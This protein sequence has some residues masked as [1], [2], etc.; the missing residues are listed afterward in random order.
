MRGLSTHL[1]F[2]V[3]AASALV[4]VSGCDG[5]GTTMRCPVGDPQS[6]YG[7]IERR[8]KE[9][10]TLYINVGSEPEYLDPTLA[11]DGASHTLVNELFEGL[12]AKHP[13]DAHPV[14]GV[15]ARYQVSD[16]NTLW[17]FHLR[18]E[19][20]WSDGKPV[21]A[22]DFVYAWIRGLTAATGARNATILYPIKNG[23]PFHQGKL[24]V[25]AEAEHLRPIPDIHQ[26]G[27]ELPKG[28]AVSILT[29]DPKPGEPK[30]E[31]LQVEVFQG[32]PTFE[33]KAAA[34]P[35]PPL[36]GFVPALSLRLDASVLGMRAV[37]DHML[38]VELEE[39]TPY[40]LEL[41]AYNSYFPV[42]RDVIERWEAAGQPDLWTRKE[43]I[44]SNGPYMLDTWK[45]RYELAFVRNPHHWSYDELAIHRIVFIEVEDYHSTMNLYQAGEIDW[46]GPSLSL[47]QNFMDLLE[48]KKDFSRSLWI[49]TY[50]YEFNTSKKPVDDA[51]V[52]R[53]LG[54][55][56]DKQLIIDK[57]TRADQVPAR[58][59]VPP[60]T[61]SGY[62]KA[63]EAARAAGT[64]PF[65]GKGHDFD[66]VLA[67]ELLGQAGY[68]VVERDGGWYAQ[69]F[70]QLE[71]LYNTSEGHRG[72][73]VAIQDMW[74][75]HLG[76]TAA[77]RNEEW[78]VLIK[79]VRDGHFQVVRYG[80]TADYNHPHT[81]L[82]TFLSYSQNNHTKWKSA[83]Y[84]ALVEKAAR[85]VDPA[86]S[87][88]LYRQAEAI[89]VAEMSKLPIY[90]YTKSTLI[91]PWVRG[92]WDNSSNEHMLRWLWIDRDWCKGG[93]N[94][95]ALEPLE[96]DK[97]QRYA[98]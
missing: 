36:R 58:H 75:T 90:F 42:R 11:A 51:R 87:I 20:K 79:N 14:Q 45:F 86:A 16:D 17:R 15:A 74:K 70:P 93:D 80:W 39:P 54:L 94:R 6:Y 89:A 46:I 97:P 63:F 35:A 2:A 26:R 64:D 55:A 10:T 1:V 41:C 84:D 33:P 76:V 48:S 18:P 65:A 49:S 37:G 12:V 82:D 21:V 31:W 44:V 67:R 40:F 53:A 95:P 29:E 72:I 85:T 43:N 73:A 52:R 96:L 57:V 5:G 98:P 22:A 28:T 60:F 77:L 19:A 71:I 23:K 9:L 13:K 24:K 7:T 25:L 27:V 47:P 4:L 8:G 68:K 59:F 3:I 32:A 61:G 38:E 62:D 66:P 92:Y 30:P 88:A 78:K 56:V 81:F 50:W 83:A 69:G 34:E 91:K